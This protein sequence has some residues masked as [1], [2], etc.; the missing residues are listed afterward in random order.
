MEWVG[1]H[2][3]QVKYEKGWI[4][5]RKNLIGFKNDSVSSKKIKRGENINS[6]TGGK[7]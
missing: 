5:H 2:L 3:R 4:Y 7:R 1:G 6:S